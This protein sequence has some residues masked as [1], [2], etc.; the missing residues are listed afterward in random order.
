MK[1]RPASYLGQNYN[2]F[3]VR[4][5]IKRKPDARP[6]TFRFITRKIVKLEGLKHV[7]VDLNTRYNI[8]KFQT[9]RVKIR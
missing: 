7:I 2:S 3:F 5:I 8:L 4:A 1:F 9:N 6:S